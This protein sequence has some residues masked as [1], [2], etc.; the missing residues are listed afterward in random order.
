MIATTGGTVANASDRHG[1]TPRDRDSERNLGDGDPDDVHALPVPVAATATND[2][3]NDDNGEQRTIASNHEN[4][5][6]VVSELPR[7]TDDLELEKAS[8][9]RGERTLATHEA[10]VNDENTAPK[11]TPNTKR[12]NP[13]VTNERRKAATTNHG[14]LP[15]ARTTTKTRLLPRSEALKRTLDESLEVQALYDDDE[16]EPPERSELNETS[17]RK[18]TRTRSDV[19]RIANPIRNAME[20]VTTSPE[21]IRG[22]ED[23]TMRA[24]NQS[25]RYRNSERS[26][27]ERRQR[28][29]QGDTLQI[30]DEEIMDAQMKSK[31]V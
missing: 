12:N 28:R 23:V 7:D 21:P 30:T 1:D 17:R 14:R 19:D 6:V 5:P 11:R 20:L 13:K 4:A 27:N 3:L 25:Q 29:K 2:D 8:S 31:M 24:T 16:N 15:N 9:T 22:P 26:A 18:P 10:V